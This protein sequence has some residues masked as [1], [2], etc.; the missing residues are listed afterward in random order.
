MKEILYNIR[1]NRL[2]YL[3]IF[4]II[5]IS[6]DS[7]LFATSGIDVLVYLKYA[8]WISLP[9]LL[10]RYIKKKPSGTTIKKGKLR[11]PVLLL[12]IASLVNFLSAGLGVILLVLQVYIAYL[13]CNSFS[14]RD[15]ARA[16]SDVVLLIS[17]YSLILYVLTML[18][19]VIPLVPVTNVVGR[20][21]MSTFGCYYFTDYGI[22]VRMSSIF[23]EPGVLGILINIA[24]LFDLFVVNRKLLTIRSLILFISILASVS[25]AGIICFLGIFGLKYLESRVSII[26]IFIPVILYIA[27]LFMSSDL[28]GFF[29]NKLSNSDDLSTMGRTSSV[30]IPLKMA[31]NSVLNFL[32]GCGNGNFRQEYIAMGK[33]LYHME[34]DP[35]G[36]STN[37]LL[38]AF[39]IFGVGFFVYLLKGIYKFAKKI[40]DGFMMSIGLFLL[41]CMMYSN[42]YMLYSIVLYTLIFY[43]QFTNVVN[44]KQYKI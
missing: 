30:F 38:N 4:S 43:G 2:L 1:T 41:I 32:F 40:S 20:T 3:L 12:L 44:H 29:F 24:M 6:D 39:A 14:M 22:Y 27:N 25:T 23:R 8:Y 5:L 35:A 11:I 28:F 19:D 17:A 37:T 42:E 21:M 31:T 36:L 13:I 9:I 26:V 15:F 7:Y 33:Q 16:F 10:N 34:I 18:L